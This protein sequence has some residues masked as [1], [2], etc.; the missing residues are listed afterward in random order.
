[1]SFP[2]GPTTLKEGQGKSAENDADELRDQETGSPPD[3]DPEAGK[4]HE[5]RHPKDTESGENFSQ[6]N[7][8][9]IAP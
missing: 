4:G 5:V 1:M 8:R 9:E 3:D 6:S 7:G 2:P